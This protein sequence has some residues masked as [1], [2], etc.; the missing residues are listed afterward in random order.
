MSPS[1]YAKKVSVFC[2]GKSR[3]P[4]YLLPEL[5][6]EIAE[7]AS[8]T[9]PHISQAPGSRLTDYAAQVKELGD[10]LWF[11]LVPNEID[12]LL[13]R[14]D[15]KAVDAAWSVYTRRTSGSD[16]RRACLRLLEL[17][18]EY[19]GNASKCVREPDTVGIRRNR[20]AKQ[21]TEMVVN[22]QLL[23]NHFGLSLE[24]VAAQNI[25][26]LESRHKRGKIEGDGGD[27]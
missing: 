10:C 4:H 16:A 27:R 26:K 19:N 6:T 7:L 2:T 20:M 11:L 24:S 9:L 3:N 22:F 5:L 13:P 21:M 12:S 8:I 14:P 17:G 1:A 25:N 23:A 15:A 18:A